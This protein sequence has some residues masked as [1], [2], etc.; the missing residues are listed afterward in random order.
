VDDIF[1]GWDSGFALADAHAAFEAGRYEKAAELYRRALESDPGDVSALT[2]L[3]TCELQLSRP[4]AAL[5]V[6][7]RAMDLAPSR[8]EPAVLATAG[9][10]G[11]GEVDRA[12][13]LA[14]E[15]VARD[16]SSPQAAL[17]WADVLLTAGQTEEAAA[18]LRE[19]AQRWPGRPQVLLA[20]SRAGLAPEEQGEVAEG[21]ASVTRDASASRELRAAAAFAEGALREKLGEHAAAVEA[22]TLANELATRRPFDPAS[23]ERL[24]GEIISAWS[25]DRLSAPPRSGVESRL[26]VFIVGMPRTG[27]TLVE[28]ILACHPAVFGAGELDLV[29]ERA[30][31]LLSGELE[32]RVS[33]L[34]EDA[35]RSAAERHLEQLRDRGGEAARVTDKLPTNFLH[36]GLI[37]AL[38]PRAAVIHCVR[39]PVDA[40]LSCWQQHFRGAHAWSH[41]FEDIAAFYAGHERLMAHWRET[42]P[43]EM[44]E[45]R[46]EDLVA[47]PERWARR[48]IDFVGL[49][50]DDRCL[51]PHKHTRAVLTA[52]RDRV[53]ER[54]DARSAGRSAAYG[55]LLDPLRVALRRRGVIGA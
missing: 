40:S 1:S 31:E 24:V 10:L 39:D 47:E 6:A 33:S 26:P 44:L 30:R 9:A 50:W 14:Q 32:A 25:A 27:T 38:F 51:A 53:R 48:L 45:V 28:Q 41:R 3:A 7:E 17:C 43:G 42:L 8:A 21:L 36:L 11:V 2:R 4:R 35:L 5:E 16:E 29:P 18:A 37:R 12:L 46:Y 20:Q 22:L 54:I 19:A 13:E 55:A 34:T 15:A 52:S 49:A 23:H